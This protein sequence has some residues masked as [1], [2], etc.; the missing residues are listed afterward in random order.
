VALFALSV[1]IVLNTQ[2]AIRVEIAFEA[3][4]ISSLNA[5]EELRA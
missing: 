1:M 2:R 3:S 4:R 5:S